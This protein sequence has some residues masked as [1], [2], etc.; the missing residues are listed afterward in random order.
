M[1]VHTYRFPVFLKSPCA[2]TCLIPSL[3]GLWKN[4]E[5]MIVIFTSINVYRSSKN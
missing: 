4:K 1:W 3:L 2:S 5:M